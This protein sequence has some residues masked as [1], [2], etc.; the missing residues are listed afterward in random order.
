MTDRHVAALRLIAPLYSIVNLTLLASG[1][2]PLPFD[3]TAVDL[4]VTTVVGVT[5][6][7]IA[8]WKNNNLTPAA[9]EAQ[10]L[11]RELKRQ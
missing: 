7:L 1:Y 4:A 8:W 9:I 3:T 2:D 10:V 11:L 6:T 5:G